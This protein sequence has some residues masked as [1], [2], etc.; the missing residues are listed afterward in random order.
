MGNMSN[1]RIIKAF[2]KKIQEFYF[3]KYNCEIKEIHYENR[4]RPK[5]GIFKITIL[6]H[7]FT[8]PHEY[9]FGFQI[10]MKKKMYEHNLSNKYYHKEGIIIYEDM[11]WDE[12]IDFSFC[13]NGITYYCREEI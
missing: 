13:F 10:D 3:D 12:F 1:D 7:I 9:T 4:K 5:N 8:T 11:T 6:T 2:H